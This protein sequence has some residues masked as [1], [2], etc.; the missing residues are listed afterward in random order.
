MPRPRNDRP[1]SN[2]IIR[3]NFGSGD[4]QQGA[5]DVGQYVAKEDARC[6]RTG[7]LG[8]FDVGQGNDLQ[9]LAKRDA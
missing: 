1:A 6:A 3:P 5:C 9:R 2:R 4:D 8:G 7:K